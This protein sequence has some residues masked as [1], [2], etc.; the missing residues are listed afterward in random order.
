M[1]VTS[2]LFDIK[3]D[4]ILGEIKSLEEISNKLKN[5]KSQSD[6]H[7][8]IEYYE[9]HESFFIDISGP[10]QK[11]KISGLKLMFS[12][13]L[14]DKINSLKS[15]VYMF[16]NTSDHTFNFENIWSLLKIWNELNF[17][18]KKLYY[19]TSSDHIKKNINRYF[20]QLGVSNKPNLLETALT[21]YPELNREP[22]EKLF[23]FMSGLLPAIKK[24]SGE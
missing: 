15:I 5:D 14:K 9:K 16:Y 2:I 18:Y 1:N 20:H 10:L 22:E 19:I 4:I 8:I 3:P 24:K 23:E 6:L 21:V 12:H 11:D 17:D 7:Y 13:I